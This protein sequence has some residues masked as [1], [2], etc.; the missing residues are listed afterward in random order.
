[1]KITISDDFD[2]NK[3]AE[4]GQCFR[5]NPE[6]SGYRFIAGDREILIKKAAEKEY[7]ISVSERE[8]H[9]FW[10]DY[11]DL[12]RNYELIRRSAKN[13]RFMARACEAGKGIRILRQDPW[14]M[15][16][17]FIISQRKSIPAI[18][19]SIERLCTCFGAKK[20]DYYAF[21]TP[22]ELYNA[23]PEKLA[24]C[25]LGYR[26]PY[27]TAA[28]KA[29]YLNDFSLEDIKTLPD[30]E[31]L[32]AL[33]TLCGVGDKVANC[34]MLFAY[35]RTASVPIDTWVKKIIEEDYGGINPFPAYKEN[36]GIMQQYAFYYKRHG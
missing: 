26:L 12:G 3:I 19:T 24:S 23:D 21:P 31:L 33:K 16:I 1:M 14:E 34:I 8:W 25:G 13:D 22:K 27:I 35:G 10:E 9:D 11:F 15:L 20:K 30:N 29:V 17:S 2:L 18:K 6:G 32:E 4:S 7:D 5:A 28:A 36:G